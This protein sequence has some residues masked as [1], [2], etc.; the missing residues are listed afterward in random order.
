MLESGIGPRAVL[1]EPGMMAENSAAEINLNLRDVMLRGIMFVP[2]FPPRAPRPGGNR[3]WLGN[4][5]GL[6]Q[7]SA[8]LL[9]RKAQS[10]GRSADV[11]KSVSYS[12]IIMIHCITRSVIAVRE[13]RPIVIYEVRV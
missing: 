12:Y 13:G 9:W 6:G 4:P 11:R 10:V 2:A 3:P 8:L 1:P 5:C 7:A